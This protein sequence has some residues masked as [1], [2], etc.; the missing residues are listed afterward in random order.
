MD[1]EKSQKI[2]KNDVDNHSSSSFNLNGGLDYI[3]ETLD[4][5]LP[6]YIK[7]IFNFSGYDT[8]LSIIQISESD[9]K[10]IE[11][12][13]RKD[14]PD[15]IP[16]DSNKSEFFGV[17][18]DNI[19]TFQFIPGHRKLLL[20]ISQKLRELQEQTVESQNKKACNKL[21]SS[22]AENGKKSKK[23]IMTK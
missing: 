1:Q 5:K 9:I 6:N 2:S 11:K 23:G 8:V 19:Q 3:E 15:L 21:S 17:Y 16:N 7:N 12:F 20:M 13:A 14:M 10:E 4:L 18:K 22:L